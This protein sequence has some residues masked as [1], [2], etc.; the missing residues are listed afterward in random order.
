MTGGPV[1]R[2]RMNS[3]IWAVVTISAGLGLSACSDADVRKAEPAAPARMQRVETPAPLFTAEAV[4]RAAWAP[5]PT[6]PEAVSP[7]LVKAQVLLDRAGFSPGVIDG[8]YGENVRQALAAYQEARNLDE[9]GELT[10]ET[11]ASLEQAAG[12]AVVAGYTLTAADVAG[13]FIAALPK[14]IPDQAMLP[15]LGYTSAAELVAERFH[16]DEDLLRAL[17][18]GVDFRRA[19][20]TVLV[21]NPARPALAAEVARIE[22]DKDEKAVKAYAEDGRLLAFY[23]ATIGSAEQPSPSGAMTVTHVQRDPLYTYDPKKLDF[24]NDRIKRRTTVKPGPNNPVGLVWIDLSRP[25]YGIHGAPEPDVIGKTASNGCV[26][27]TN[28]DA[29]A[30]AAAVKPGVKVRFL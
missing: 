30:L 17:N 5:P 15:H 8:R 1:E 10:P 12:P 22:V 14:E 23:P 11:F 13:P 4:N 26:R 9:T 21:A 18:P 28:W 27:L 6:E 29:L 16:M 25:T 2:N 19:G 7:Q 3:R 20:V 24:A